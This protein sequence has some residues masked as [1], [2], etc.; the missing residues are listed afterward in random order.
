MIK[1][2]YL[3]VHCIH[4]ISVSMY[5]SSQDENA[6]QTESESVIGSR[7]GT[8][9]RRALDGPQLP[10]KRYQRAGVFSTTYKGDEYVLTP[11]ISYN[12]VCTAVN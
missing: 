8:P 9:A 2:I 12:N 11:C 5:D 6:S 3:K 10:R 1:E 7:P 4:S